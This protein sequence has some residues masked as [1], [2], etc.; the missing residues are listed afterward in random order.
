MAAKKLSINL[1]DK[2]RSF[3]EKIKTEQPAPYGV[4]VNTLISTFCDIPVSVRTDLLEFIKPKINELFQQTDAAGEFNLKAIKEDIRAY[5]DIASFFYKKRNSE[6][7]LGKK[8]FMIPVLDSQKFTIDL[9]DKNRNL[10]EQIKTEQQLPYGTTINILIS[11]F[12][13]V[14]LSVKKEFLEFIKLKLKNLY[15]QMDAAGEFNFIDISEQAQSYLDIAKFFNNGI[16]YSVSDIDAVSNMLK[17][18]ILNGTLICPDDVIL[19]NPEKASC[20]AYACIIEC[21]NSN[22]Y[23]IPHFVFFSN[24]QFVGDYDVT[25]EKI[26]YV[27]CQKVYPRFG[28]ILSKQV[29]PIYD[30]DNPGFLLNFKEWNQAPT[31]CLYDIY[32]QGDPKYGPDYDPPLN[33]RIIRSSNTNKK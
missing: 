11:T 4:I 23:N 27:E 32:V 16:R 14:P 8:L 30:P 12:C 22:K 6:A 21:R 17:V 19:I 28:E 18:P 29:E 10:L 33:I 1:T 24:I 25:Y 20:S 7:K 2:N 15:Q 13:N 5:T 3:L 9:T 31:I 26:I